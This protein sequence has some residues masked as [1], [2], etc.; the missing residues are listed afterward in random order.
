MNFLHSGIKVH[1]ALF[2]N[3]S[4]LRVGFGLDQ[5]SQ[6]LLALLKIES[7]MAGSRNSNK[8]R[9]YEPIASREIEWEAANTPYPSL[10]IS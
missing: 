4:I 7:F 2:P 1:T 3:P 9:N 10:E 5:G 6:G 8:G